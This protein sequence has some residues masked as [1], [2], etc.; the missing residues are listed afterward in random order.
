MDRARFERPDSIKTVS[1]QQLR[2]AL[3]DTTENMKS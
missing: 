1:T 2:E 3:H